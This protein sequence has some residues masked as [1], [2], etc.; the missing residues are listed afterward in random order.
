MISPVAKAKIM[1]KIAKEYSE[2]R[3]PDIINAFACDATQVLS[4]ISSVLLKAVQHLGRIGHGQK[5][6]G[7]QQIKALSGRR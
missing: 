6:A 4:K 7:S 2:K 5:I 3:D 1:K